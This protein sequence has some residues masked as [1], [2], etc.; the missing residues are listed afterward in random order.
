LLRL[1]RNTLYPQ[2][3]A[4]TSATSGGRSVGIVRLQTKAT[5]FYAKALN[6]ANPLS[7]R[8]LLLLLLLTGYWWESQKERDR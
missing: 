4:L 7:E 6:M 2:K 3:L 5:E 1:P 8:L